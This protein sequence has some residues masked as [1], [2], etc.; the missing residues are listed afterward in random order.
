MSGTYHELKEFLRVTDA[1]ELAF[2]RTERVR[3]AIRQ[4]R[5]YSIVE[6]LKRADQ[7][8]EC[9]VV[10]VE[11]DGVPP[12]NIHK[13]M[14][15]E[16][17]ALCIPENG[18]QLVEVYA[19]R[20]DFP[21][22][23]HQNLSPPDS[24][25]SLCLYFEPPVSVTRSWTP[26]KF[27][28]RIQWWLEKSAKGELHPADQPIEQLFY[29]SGDE[30]V[31]PWN[32]EEVRDKAEHELVIFYGELRPNGHR[33]YFLRALPKGAREKGTARY[34]RILS[35]PIAQ[36]TIE[37]IPGTLGELAEILSARG[38]EILPELKQSLRLGIGSE[39]V[40]ESTDQDLTILLLH[41]P[42][43][44][45]DGLVHGATEKAFAV[46]CG[47]YKLGV[48]TGALISPP[49]HIGSKQQYYSSEV[50]E[51]LGGAAI[52]SEWRGLPIFP[53]DVLRQ[54]DA[55]SA[56]KQSGLADEGP[57]G[58]MIG[59]GSLG[60]ALINIWG[61]TG[62]GKW[63]VID[64]DHIK[65]HNLS[66]H[67]AHALD[68]GKPKAS[69][70]AELHDSVMDGASNITP[71]NVDVCNFSQPPVTNALMSA[72]LVI[73]ASTTLEYP[74]AVSGVDNVGRHIS[75]FITPKGTDAVLLAED[76]E[77]K[78]R[79]RTLEAQYYR[80][81]IQEVWGQDH[82][83][84]N[85]GSYWSGASCRDIS[86]VMPY[87]RILNHASTLAEQIPTIAASHKP[88]IR[89]WKRDPEQGT[90]VVHDVIPSKEI[91]DRFGDWEL[92]M[93]EGLLDRIREWRATRL[94]SET[95]GVLL[96]YYDFNVS[97]I[98]VV[99]ALPP[100]P[101]SKGSSRSFQRG[102][103]GLLNTVREASRRTAG[104]VEY[105]GEWHSHPPK[106]SASPSEDDLIQLADLTRKMSE[107]GLPAVQLIVGEQDIQILQGT[108]KE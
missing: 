85:L 102:I 103:E 104:T 21:I 20:K 91:R 52:T 46:K 79:L 39:G 60:S 89:I 35:P 26:Q 11:T 13:I 100:P 108:I 66:R 73:D 86:L 97:A 27:L 15:R 2:D 32:F 67:T 29:T 62:W 24:P 81:L 69:V 76:E 7:K 14:Y 18:K 72:Q 61:R 47:P 78:I 87:S 94:P 10:D 5:D 43:T 63:T 95:G 31:L 107:D 6:L 8:V 64:N 54:N 16:R 55:S 75:V 17:L 88:K 92:F 101:D 42:L 53:M 28:R 65:P 93:D 82:L 50:S 70:V 3:A 25:R 40:Q 99:A 45:E 41:V 22:L 77:R 80:A 74:R 71:L 90:T 57:T 30:L 38:V 56:R 12:H 23:M 59:A 9:I 49:T 36:G 83:D 19:L 105:I 98:T 34:I 96:G 37:G 68:I 106:H 84:G 33:T 48:A 1:G 44:R 51:A 4:E 58:I